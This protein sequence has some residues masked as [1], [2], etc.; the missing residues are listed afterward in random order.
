MAA[1]GGLRMTVDLIK[2]KS[3]QFDLESIQWLDMTGC[4][5]PTMENLSELTSLQELKLGRNNLRK[6]EGLGADKPRLTSLDL[7]DNK[8]TTLEGLSGLT[9]LRSLRLEGNK[10]G[11]VSELN[12]LL[13]LTNLRQLWLATPAA[14]TKKN[15]LCDHPSYMSVVM[16]T[17]PQLEMIDGEHMVLREKSQAVL[18][19][20]VTVDE[21]EV[22]E[23]VDRL[24]GGKWTAGVDTEAPMVVTD[25]ATKRL[26]N[27]FEE[28]LAGAID[29]EAKADK[30][31]KRLG[32]GK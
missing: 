11:D 16:R 10:I 13:P 18:R 14:S 31:L 23:E 4:G 5:I 26:H 32:R 15:P 9:A 28:E 1:G 29:L 6:V 25:V 22:D 12:R 19:D 2:A 30:L 3:G 21:K 27:E 8:L 20:S 7:S 17:L 24:A